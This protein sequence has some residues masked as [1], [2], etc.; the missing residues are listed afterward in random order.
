MPFDLI[1]DFGNRVIAKRGNADQQQVRDQR[2]DREAQKSEMVIPIRP[3]VA[4]Q[5]DDTDVAEI[6]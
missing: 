4:N 2:D 5:I 3:R 6:E 1:G